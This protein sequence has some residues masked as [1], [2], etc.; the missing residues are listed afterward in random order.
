MLSQSIYGDLAGVA[1][2][3]FVQRTESRNVFG[4]E[5]VT[6]GYDIQL[7]NSDPERPF[8]RPAHPLVRPTTTVAGGLGL[9]AGTSSMQPGEK[10]FQA[11]IWCVEQDEELDAN[12][13]ASVF[14]AEIVVHR[15]L[16]FEDEALFYASD[17]MLWN[18]QRLTD[19]SRWRGVV[20]VDSLVDGPIIGDVPQRVDNTVSYSCL[21]TFRL[22]PD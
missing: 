10:A 18:Q 16:L 13:P 7:G 14:G 21:A 11:R 20:G 15:T 9:V 8:V 17:E 19:K 2:S 3:G 4:D 12:I 5:I 1:G 22:T 6:P